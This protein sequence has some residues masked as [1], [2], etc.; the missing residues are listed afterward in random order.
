MPRQKPSQ[1]SSNKVLLNLKHE[2]QPS[3]LLPSLSAGLVNG[4]LIII[5]EISFAAMIFSG[6]LSGLVSRGIGLTLLGAFVICIVVALTSSLPGAVGLPQDGPAAILAL[7]AAAI[8]ANM[9]SASEEEIFSTVVTAIAFST[10]LTGLFF[11][12]MGRFRLGNLVRFI[13]YPVVGGFLAGIGWLLFQGGFSVMADASLNLSQLPYLFQSHVMIKW[14]PGLIF[15]A[16]L[17]FI[18]RCTN[19]YLVMPGM[20]LGALCTFYLL[21]FLTGLSVAEAGSRGWL[22]GPFPEGPLWQWPGLSA[23]T[24]TRWGIIF[25][26]MGNMG[27]ILVISIISVLLY[28]SGLELALRR[29][30]DLN[31]ELKSTGMANLFACIGFSPAGYIALSLSALSHKVGSDSRLVGLFSAALCGAALFFGASSLSYFPKS[32]AG[33]LVILIG[34][35]FLTAWVYEGWFKLPKIDYCLVLLI[36]VVIGIFGFL[37]GVAVG[38]VVAVMVF[39]V[40]YSRVSVIKYALSGLTYQSSVDRTVPDRWL[41]NQKGEQIH[42][43]K[44]QGFIFFGTANNLLNR[45]LERLNDPHQLPLS[46]VVLDFSQVTGLDSSALNSFERM[47]QLA[48][49]REFQLIFTHLSPQL[50][51]QFHKGDIEGKGVRVMKIF[52]DLD[53]GVEWCEDQVIT[54]ER[55][56]LGVEGGARQRKKKDVIFESTFDDMMKALEQQELFEALLE[57]MM[58]YLELRQVQEGECLIR[59][60]NLPAGIY[61]IESGQMTDQFEQDD[62]KAVRLRTMG[63]GS[64]VGE[65]GLYSGLSASSSVISNELSVVHFLSIDKVQEMEVKDP[66]IAAGLHRYMSRLLSE[67]LAATNRTIQTII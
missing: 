12:L 43:L 55:A 39:I 18:L 41:L 34:L 47:T 37:E 10:F 42:I 3:R 33:S 26:H 53:H 64:V 17:L 40:K 63:V 57:R 65:S 13:P 66:E 7:I 15:G 36:L 11:V 46:Y 28:A 35:D 30:M 51:R 4:I 20:L 23:L 6:D 32:V 49:A 58:P 8:A 14:L 16:L 25:G 45:V 56:A 59:Q 31:R 52:P 44:L 48:E 60:G 22:L 50:Q 29:D 5:L 2:I 21:L 19:H 24:Q 27:T 61:F 54:L 1:P 38:V 62:G 67:R 9:I